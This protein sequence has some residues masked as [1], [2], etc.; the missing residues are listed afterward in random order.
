MPFHRVYRQPRITVIKVKRLLLKFWLRD[1]S[2]PGN[3]ERQEHIHGN[4]GGSLATEKGW[5][6]YP[7]ADT[8]INV[9]CPVTVGGNQ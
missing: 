8:K 5:A 4:I 2:A 3:Y 9:T 6:S 1:K 7:A